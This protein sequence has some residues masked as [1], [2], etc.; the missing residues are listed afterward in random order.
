MAFP[1]PQLTRPCQWFSCLGFRKPRPSLLGSLLSSAEFWLHVP[2]LLRSRGRPSRL[3][4]ARSKGSALPA[5]PRLRRGYPT[6]KGGPPPLLGLSPG[7]CG[8]GWAV[9]YLTHGT[10]TSMGRFSQMDLA[11]M[12]GFNSS[13]ELIHTVGILGGSLHGCGCD[14]R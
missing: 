1:S 7:L 2:A 10:V 8:P 9:A 14:H 4:Q 12:L 11:R 5:H 6:E 3:H 13:D